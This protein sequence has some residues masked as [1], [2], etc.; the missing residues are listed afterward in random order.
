MCM[1]ANK[2][3]LYDRTSLWVESVYRLPAFVVFVLLLWWILVLRFKVC[4]QTSQWRCMR[5][6]LVSLLKRYEGSFSSYKMCNQVFNFGSTSMHFNCRSRVITKSSTSARPNWR[7]YIKT[8][9]QKTLENS[10]PIDSSTTSLLK[11]LEVCSAQPC[12]S[13]PLILKY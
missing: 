2:W 9:L 7:H 6:M 10:Q 1:H 3:N 13:Q 5:R 12:V 4:V 8:T 11:T